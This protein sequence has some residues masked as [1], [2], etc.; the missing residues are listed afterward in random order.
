MVVTALVAVGATLR[1]QMYLFD[2]PLWWPEAALALNILRRSGWALLGPY[3]FHQAAPIGFV[4]ITK[5]GTLLFGDSE[6]V[7]RLPAFLFGLA[8]LP[9]FYMAA[10]AYVSQ[11]AAL[12]ALAFF[13]LSPSAIYW[14]ST[15]KQYSS[16][17]T[18]A[19]AALMLGSWLVRNPL[20]PRRAVAAALF[21]VVGMFFSFPLVF[22][23]SGLAAGLAHDD[24]ARR[25]WRALFRL[26]PVCVAWAVGFAV[27]YR[28][29]LRTFDLDGFLKIFWARA[30]SQPVGLASQLC[31]GG[32]RIHRAAR[33]RDR[34]SMAA[35]SRVRAGSLGDLRST[36]GPRAISR[37]ACCRARDSLALPDVSVL[38]PHDSFRAS[39]AAAADV[40]RRRRHRASGESRCGDLLAQPWRWHWSRC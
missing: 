39:V 30:I 27:H 13:A 18:F 8:S 34:S 21:G 32:E 23:L 38:A 31:A 6:R 2:K 20:T 33:S 35:D 10:R 28:I 7:L 4:L 24:M 19:I 36:S 25:D 1:L 29:S 17:L 5:A 11:A 14:A 3:D 22:L 9:L 26:I 16:D 15:C 37:R 40:R 12:L